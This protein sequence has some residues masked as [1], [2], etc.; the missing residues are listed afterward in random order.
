MTAVEQERNSIRTVALSD[1]AIRIVHDNYT[2][3]DS[4]K[5]AWGFSAYVTGPEKNIL[6]DTGSDGALLLENMAKM[7]IEPHSVEIVVLSHVH[8]DHTGG[9]MGL[10][11]ENPQVQ[12]YLPAVLPSRFK[13]AVRG[14]GAVII[15]IGE[16]QEICPNVYTTGI[17]GRLIRE[18]ALII[19]TE[20][21][22]IVLTGCAHPGIARIVEKVR[23]LHEESILL[24]V[25]GFHLEWAAKRKVEKIITVFREHDVRYVAPT[26]CSGEKARQLFQQHYGPSCIAVGAGKTIAVADLFS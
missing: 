11:K 7:Q 14:Y 18:Q 17:M 5:T 19:R 4:L 22:L 9:L 15:E 16:P 3:D 12:V 13:D 8:G 20:R 2:H 26:H 24:I 25:G 1:L 23:G 21:G 6:F 10:L